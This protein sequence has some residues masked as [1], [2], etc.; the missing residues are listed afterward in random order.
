VRDA[1]EAVTEYVGGWRRE[2]LGASDAVEAVVEG[3]EGG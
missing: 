3:A 1:R 2:L